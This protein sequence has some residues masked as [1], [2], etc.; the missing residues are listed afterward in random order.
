[1]WKADCVAWRSET[2]EVRSRSRRACSDVAQGTVPLIVEDGHAFVVGELQPYGATWQ[3]PLCRYHATQYGALHGQMKCARNDCHHAEAGE[4]EGLRLC[5]HHLA[6]LRSAIPQARAQPMPCEP[7]PA[8]PSSS[9]PRPLGQSTP[10]RAPEATPVG[11]DPPLGSHAATTFRACLAGPPGS[12]QIPAFYHFAACEVGGGGSG[13]SQELHF[14]LPSLGRQVVV[15]AA[16][17]GSWKMHRLAQLQAYGRSALVE[18]VLEPVGAEEEGGHCQGLCQP[19]RPRDQPM[20]P[21]VDPVPATTTGATW[22]PSSPQ[23]PFTGLPSR[24]ERAPTPRRATSRLRRCK[25]YSTSRP[26]KSYQD[27]GAS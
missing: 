2:G 19:P 9:S 17:V 18:R 1:M 11:L 8:L 12:A 10:R 14:L 25:P 23:R 3:V 24:A 7:A 4:A 27:C 21:S 22:T 15:D 6:G 20:P 5:A 16:E 26:W 13:S